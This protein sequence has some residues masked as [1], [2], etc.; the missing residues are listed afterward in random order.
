MWDNDIIVISS[1]ISL[2]PPP[3]LYMQWS[4]AEWGEGGHAYQMSTCIPF[5]MQLIQLKFSVTTADT[6]LAA[7]EPADQSTLY[8]EQCQEICDREPADQS[9]V[10]MKMNNRNF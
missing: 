3:P 8:K 7:R 2:Y 10:R 4:P 1:G 9:T 5:K 6:P